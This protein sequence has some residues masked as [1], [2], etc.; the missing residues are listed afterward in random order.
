MSLMF[1]TDSYER[2]LY[3]I[4]TVSGPSTVPCPPLRVYGL[5]FFTPSVTHVS[6]KQTQVTYKKLPHINNG[7]KFKADFM[8]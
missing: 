1:L 7:F 6:T 5:F 3:M 8:S 4:P 2:F